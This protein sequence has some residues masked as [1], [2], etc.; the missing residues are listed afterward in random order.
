MVNRRFDYSGNKQITVEKAESVSPAVWVAFAQDSDGNCILEKQTI[1][2]PDESFYSITRAVDEII[3]MSFNSSDIYVIYEDDTLFAERFSLTNPLT[4]YFSVE[5][6]VGVVETPVQIISDDTNVYVLTPGTA[7]GENAKIIIYDTSLTYIETIDLTKSGS[8]VTDAISFTIDDTGDI[9][10][11]TYTDPATF[12]R[13]F[14]LSGG[15]YDF[16]V[17]EV[18]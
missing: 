4:S 1:Y 15:G 12:V 11:V 9:W 17:T 3:D 8:E 7:S 13:V 18:I 16:E 10:V 2:S 6:P 14:E 5:Y